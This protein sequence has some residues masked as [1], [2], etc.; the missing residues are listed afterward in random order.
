MNH[1]VEKKIYNPNGCELNVVYHCN[2]SCRACSHLSPTF[3]KYF[4]DP[5]KVL[6][7]L[8]IL[9]KYY[10]ANYLKIMG[11]EPLLHPDLIEVIDAVRSSGISDFIQVAT[12]GQLLSRVS[13]VFWSK[14]DQIYISVYPGRELSEENF[15]TFEQKAKLHNVILEY[16]YFDSFRESY[17][18]L[19]TRDTSLVQRIYS[20]CKM[21]HIWHSHS[22]ADGYFY[23]CPQSLFLPK[24]INNDILLPNKDGVK[25]TDSKEFY[26]K[27]LVYLEST[28]PL[29]ACYNCLGSVGKLFAHEQKKPNTWRSQQ[30][31]ITEEL[32]DMEY[33]AI[34]EENPDA[35][36]SCMRSRSPVEKVISRINRVQRTLGRRL[37]R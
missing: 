7:D 3:A 2:L 31:Y 12:N 4:V 24:V 37:I 10:K 27:L 23:K 8:S 28:E 21:A 6:D 36:N 25:I 33:L 20:S 5:K 14:I 30:Q 17:S 29:S 16:F 34:L 11:G 19:G 13:D 9:G 15:K 26:K 1:I 22:V 18:E 32:I 35:N